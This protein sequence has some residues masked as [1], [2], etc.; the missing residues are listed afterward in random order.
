[1]RTRGSPTLGI[2][3]PIGGVK[4]RAQY[5]GIVGHFQS[6]PLS[7]ARASGARALIPTLELELSAAS[8]LALAVPEGPREEWPRRGGRCAALRRDARRTLEHRRFQYRQSR[9]I[10]ALT[11]GRGSK[12]VA[13]VHCRIV[14]H[15]GG[16]AYK[17]NDVFSEPFPTKSI[18]LAAAKRV[19]SEQHIPGDT[20][21]IEYQDEAGAWHSEL[22]QADDRPDADV[23][24]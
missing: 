16:W 1:M 8:V 23:V 14:A 15:D 2:V 22:S 18:A 5:S 21:H 12:A 6:T 11:K 4:W 19:A 7:A 10:S 20:T 3:R 13:R 17:L 24:A 9:V